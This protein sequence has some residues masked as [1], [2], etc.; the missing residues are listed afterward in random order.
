MEEASV[1]EGGCSFSQPEIDVDSEDDY[2]ELT[3]CSLQTQTTQGFG[4]VWC[5]ADSSCDCL[6]HESR[7]YGNWRADFINTNIRHYPDGPVHYLYSAR[8]E[9]GGCRAI[10]EA[11][12][13][14]RYGADCQCWW[15]A[16]AADR[17]AELAEVGYETDGSDISLTD[18]EIPLIVRRSDLP[19]YCHCYRSGNN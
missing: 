19:L 7:R 11:L 4:L 2:T 18:E 8:N 9:C 13:L 1:V 10:L 15:C 6:F 16:G 12:H 3:R 5:S 17:A 14:E